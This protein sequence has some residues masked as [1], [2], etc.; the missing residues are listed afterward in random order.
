MNFFVNNADAIINAI[1][2]NYILNNIQNIQFC[3]SRALT[4][5]GGK[6]C[7]VELYIK[8][9]AKSPFIKFAYL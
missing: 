9:S 1:P 3:T 7:Y 4:I 2:N 8:F 6:K 5:N